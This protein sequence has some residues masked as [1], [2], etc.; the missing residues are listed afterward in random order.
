MRLL[1]APLM[2]ARVSRNEGVRAPGRCTARHLLVCMYHWRPPTLR[3]AR[4]Q[5]APARIRPV[6]RQLHTERKTAAVRITTRRA[7]KKLR[8]TSFGAS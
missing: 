1:H 7:Q 8:V 4:P 2:L 5:P 6:G 3:I